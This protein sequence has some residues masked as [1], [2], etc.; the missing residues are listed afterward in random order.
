MALVLPE[1]D[2]GWVLDKFPI[3]V[4]CSAAYPS[5]STVHC[6]FVFGHPL[7]WNVSVSAFWPGMDIYV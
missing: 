5:L 3:A 2:A 4:H 1:R 6:S 7:S